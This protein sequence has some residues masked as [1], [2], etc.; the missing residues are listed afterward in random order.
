[1]VAY[2][3]AMFFNKNFYYKQFKWLTIKSMYKQTRLEIKWLLSDFASYLWCAENDQY[4]SNGKFI[5]RAVN[6]D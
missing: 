5:P 3:I 4:C 6:N 1:M 2:V